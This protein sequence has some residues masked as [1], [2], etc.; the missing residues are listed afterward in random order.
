MIKVVELF[1]GIGGFRKGFA[2]AAEETHREVSFE[3]VSEWDKFAQTS[4]EAS[5]GEKPQGDI[6]KVDAR[7][8]PDHDISRCVL[9]CHDAALFVYA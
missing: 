5:W 4:Y 9:H 6:T 3:F 1:A 2:D 7:D 8:I